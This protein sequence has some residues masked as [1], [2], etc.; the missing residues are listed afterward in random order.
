METHGINNMSQ[1]ER[2]QRHKVA[3]PQDE[4]RR[5][6]KQRQSESVM[7]FH[8]KRNH[9]YGYGLPDS[10]DCTSEAFKRVRDEYL[11]RAEESVEVVS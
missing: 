6:E 9:L 7:L 4:S 5:K 3:H 11:A 1:R 10:I 8:I 2:Q